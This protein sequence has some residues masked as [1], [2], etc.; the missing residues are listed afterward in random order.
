MFNKK[1]QVEKVEMVKKIIRDNDYA[2]Y[3]KAHRECVELGIKVNRPA[4]DNFGKKLQQLDKAAKPKLEFDAPPGE[5]IQLSEPTIKEEPTIIEEPTTIP[6]TAYTSNKT[7]FDTMSFDDMKR[8]EDE[9]TFELG[10]L[11]IKENELLVE[12]SHIKKRASN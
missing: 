5:E 1:L 11:K 2:N 6:D 10:A 8:R 7:K 9:I 3:A 12:L 4:L